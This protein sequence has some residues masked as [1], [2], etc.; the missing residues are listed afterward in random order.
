MHTQA[1]HGDNT[2]FYKLWC[3]DPAITDIYVGHTDFTRRKFTHKLVA[4]M[5]KRSSIIHINTNV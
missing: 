2:L 4:V 5:K 3:K 1:I